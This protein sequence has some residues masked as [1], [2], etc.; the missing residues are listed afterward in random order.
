[1]Y[2]Q[3]LEMVGFK[4]FAPKTVLEFHK[5][6]TAVVGPNGCGKSNVLDALRWVLGEQSAKALRGGE[7]ADV[8]FSGTDSRQALGMAEVSMTFSDCEKELGVEWN[9][10]RITRRVFRDGK[11]EYLLNKAPCRLKD[12]QQLFMDTGIGRSAYSI[13]EQGKID[14]ILS[15]RPEDRRAIFEEAAGIT[16]YKAQKKEALRKLEYTEANLLRVTDIIKEVKRQIG[17]LQRQAG[18]A[19]RYQALMS[20]L[21]TFDTHLSHRNCA[22]L[23]AEL[24][25][26]REELS[27]GEETRERHE[28]EI[29]ARE[30]ELAGVRAQLAELDE[31]AG[32]VRETIQDQKNR[33]SAAEH[34]IATNG[35]RCDEARA[36]I[37]RNRAEIATGKDK[38]REQESQIARTDEM[39]EEM[40]QVLRL[41]EEQL[42]EASE[43]VRAARDDRAEIERSVQQ[44]GFEI[45]RMESELN[46]LRGEASG[47]AGR[48]EAGE[49][50]RGILDAELAGAAETHEQLCRRTTEADARL[51]SAE[52]ALAAAHAEQEEAQA[53]HDE[54]QRERQRT[55][56]DLNAATRQLAEHESK[57]E[58]LVQLSAEG[59]GF[60]EGTQAVLR[61]LDNPEFFKPAVMGA[62]ASFIEVDQPYIPAME[63]AFGIGLQAILF[64]DGSVAEVAAQTLAAKKLGKAAL[65]PREWL[66]EMR[67]REDG[68]PL[69]EGA[70]GWARDFVRANDEV[71]PLVD[72]LLG[73]IVLVDSL[74]TACRL[75]PGRP[76]LGF[77]TLSGEF[78]SRDGLIHGGRTG[79]NST[80]ALLRKAQIAQLD[81]D[82][83]AGRETVRLASERRAAALEQLETAHERMQQAREAV[84]AAQVEH[85]T[86]QSERSLLERQAREAES[87]RENLIREAAQL[88]E[89]VASALEKVAAL[90]GRMAELAARIEA[91]R[92]R[93]SQASSQIDA[94]RERERFSTEELNELRVRVATERHQQENLTSQRGPMAARLAELGELL[95][96]RGR[97]IESHETRIAQFRHG[98]AELE[99]SI[100]N[101]RLLLASGE[102]QVTQL[103]AQRS[104]LREEAGLID[105]RLR[106]A[107]RELTELQENRGRME[108]RATQ[109]EMRAEHIIEHV[110]RRYQVDLKEF[111]PDSYALRAAVKGRGEDAET[112]GDAGMEFGIDWSRIEGFV[113][114]LTEKVDGM[115]PVNIDAIQEYDELEE[116][117]TFLESQNTDLVNSKAELLEVIAKINRTTKELFAETFEKIR[118]NFQE[119]FTELFGGGKANLIL[120]DESDPLEC[121]IDIIAKPPGKQLQSI[122]LLS[123]GE[124]TMTAVA[125]LFSI[126]MVK[127]SPFCVLDEMDAPLDESNINRFIKILDR[128]VDQSQFVVI[129]HNK[130]T[131]ARADEV[132]GVTMEEHG[133]SKLVSVRFAG[134]Y[135]P[136]TN[137][138][139]NGHGR[140]VAEAF[141]KD[142]RLH[143]ERSVEAHSVVIAG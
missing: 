59:E 92:D 81:R 75:R 26:V 30:A 17:S 15:S 95:D 16:K 125:L 23:M 60:D 142:D 49:A 111:H 115:G 85:S 36:M 107:R 64:K 126:Y 143:S 89:T 118:V 139:A 19:R 82:V 87:R 127:P 129:T 6:V 73:G 134:R 69:P 88:D 80:S 11:S 45:S 136:E 117:Y 83:V 71:T 3:S 20:D 106:A 33:I 67:N 122:S 74:E 77:A 108:V 94:A 141:G 109:L 84:Q 76:G 113:A 102:E 96:Q 29:E 86:A 35:E 137:G 62:L 103:V 124:K 38:M 63:A 51:G 135:E 52:T 1:M 128:F 93:Q 57:L 12:I 110:H 41:G 100:A 53:A 61:G 47:A 54:A 25:T 97:D 138:S 8:I 131:I 105:E 104:A 24:T 116:R 70:I 91:A 101:W 22:E 123:G 21:R 65:V 58:V 120:V 18:K 78:I 13:M 31:K 27:C 28:R 37:E 114:E 140:S 9:E 98:S 40:L 56:A 7:M 99:Q 79:E 90:E 48:R 34:R 130:R 72:G 42:S 14:A 68:W 4:S 55:E 39:I 2:L 43:R 121:G 133:V 5:G 50:R 32:G 119:M 66:A 46:G 132:F 10:V 44:I 112:Q